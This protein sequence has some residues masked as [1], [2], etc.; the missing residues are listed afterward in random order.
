MMTLR[1]PFVLPALPCDRSNLAPDDRPRNNAA[2]RESS[3]IAAE[4]HLSGRNE[5][6]RRRQIK[7]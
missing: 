4:W 2:S 6:S 3:G 7:K 5:E 1:F